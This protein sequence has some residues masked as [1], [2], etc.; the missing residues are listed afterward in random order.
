L[1]YSYYGLRLYTGIE[2]YVRRARKGIHSATAQVNNWDPR[3]R[4][5]GFQLFTQIGDFRVR[6][7][8]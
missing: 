8:S 4:L 2:T 6:Q 5:G 1:N 7:S 3:G